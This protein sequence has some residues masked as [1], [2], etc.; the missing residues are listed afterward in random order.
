MTPAAD[1]NSKSVEGTPKT[2]VEE[3][4]DRFYG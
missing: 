2:T 1:N 3:P 4:K